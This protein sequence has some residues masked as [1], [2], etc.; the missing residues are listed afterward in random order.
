MSVPKPLKKL[1]A[2]IGKAAN[3]KPLPI[4]KPLKTLEPVPDPIAGVVDYTDDIECDA[5][6]E[7]NAVQSGFRDRM[8][9]EQERFA[10]A[11]GSNF[12]FC[13]VFD[14]GD[15][16][17]A[18]LKATGIG[19]TEGDLFVDGRKLADR[20]GIAVPESK[21]RLDRPLNVDPK[22]KRLTGIKAD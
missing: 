18:F 19:P 20:L 1:Q 2:S 3:A 15:Q 16:V 21:I 5:S 10:G 13:V 7:L 12:Y 17:D 22:L 6:A 14:D 11:T 9:Q 8:K 4:R